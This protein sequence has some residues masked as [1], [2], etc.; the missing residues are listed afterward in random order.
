M[1]GINELFLQLLSL[2]IKKGRKNFKLQIH[3]KQG[4]QNFICP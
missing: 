1:A 3:F 2:R 4:P